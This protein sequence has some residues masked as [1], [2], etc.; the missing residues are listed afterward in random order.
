MTL[1]RLLQLTLVPLLIL[2]PLIPCMRDFNHPPGETKMDD[3]GGMYFGARCVVKRL[4]PY[5]Q[6]VALQEFRS[7]G[8]KIQGS[9]RPAE[10]TREVFTVGVNLPT[11]FLLMLPIALLPWNM[12]QIIWLI[13]IALGMG[14]AAMAM[15]D[16]G[17]EYVGWIS[18]VLVC[19]VLVNTEA[20]YLIGNVATIVVSFCVLAAWCFRKRT[21]EIAGVILLGL[22]LVLKPHDAGLVWLYLLIAGGDLRKRALQSLGL[23]AVLGILSLVW[24]API[25]PHW[26]A[27]MHQN[28]AMVDQRGGN[29]DP[30][31]TGPSAGAI[32]QIIDLQAAFSVFR[33]D[34]GFYNPVS[35]AV[36]GV[37]ILIWLLALW[38][39]KASCGVNWL[40]L[41]P[42][43]VL[44]LLPVYHRNYDA[45]LML[46]LVPACAMVWVAGGARRWIVLGL[47]LLALVTTGDLWIVLVPRTAKSLQLSL[48][49]LIGDHLATILLLRTAVPVLL[50]TGSYYV[51]VYV[52]SQMSPREAGWNALTMEER[53]DCLQ[54]K[55][56][57]RI[58]P[59]QCNYL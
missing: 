22:A 48:A 26:L 37:P 1:N 20:P 57:A 12:A 36:A 29:S 5:D 52:M 6:A 59:I 15:W 21:M 45:R 19:L 47:T 53:A 4:D 11:S 55:A 35:Y 28:H 50:A 2:I 9:G 10:V 25:S 23:A 43:S 27:E 49:H 42:A 38:Q 14:F 51:W 58:D 3:F 24:V 56:A 39:S 41:S 33:D 46:L 34:P 54:P 16:A 18:G 17:A 13:L 32:G 30:G 8:G 7:E 40:A 31:P 44:V